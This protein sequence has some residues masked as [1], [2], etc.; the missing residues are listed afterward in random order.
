MI[1]LHETFY[2]ESGLFMPKMNSFQRD[3][4]VLIGL[5][6]LQVIFAFNFPLHQL[7][8]GATATIQR[9]FITFSATAGD[10]TITYVPILTIIY[11]L[12]LVG[13]LFFK[14][15]PLTLIYG[16][17]LM[18]LT[19]FNFLNEL[20][21]MSG[22]T[23]NVRTDG[24]FTTRVL[25]DGEVVASD[26]TFYVLIVLILIKFSII[27]HQAFLKR[28]NHKKQIMNEKNVL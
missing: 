6:F 27:G 17:G 14:N 16:I 5:L 25:V 2:K 10:T 8:D 12:V 26:I 4:L 13:L 9:D 22:Q 3:A 18:L 20:N 24:L 19:K 11:S 21:Q 28:M 1:G 7:S 15:K 23:Q